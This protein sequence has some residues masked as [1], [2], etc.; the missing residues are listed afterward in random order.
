MPRRLAKSSTFL[1]LLP[2]LITSFLCCVGLAGGQVSPGTPSWAAYDRHAA[3][4]INLSNNNIYLEIPQFS[5]AGS[6]PLSLST[7]T[8]S[9]MFVNTSSQWQT[10]T[11]SPYLTSV[12]NMLA[13]GGIVTLIYPT[14]YSGGFTCP[15][16][17]S[18]LKSWGFVVQMPDG[19]IHNFPASDYTLYGTNCDTSFTDMTCPL[20][21]F[22]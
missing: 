15:G 9:Y 18:A 21:S 2:F 7:K 1:P 16:G 5:K 4:N 14:A 13:G 3:D 6:L 12:N 8:N 17:G 11:Q 19:T 20:L 22:T 10:G